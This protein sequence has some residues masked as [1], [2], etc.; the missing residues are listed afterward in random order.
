MSTAQCV[1]VAVGNI[2][3]AGA[4]QRIYAPHLSVCRHSARLASKRRRLC[5]F[6][7][8]SMRQTEL[9][10]Y[11]PAVP[12][13]VQPA[14]M[15][16]GEDGWVDVQKQLY[17]DLCE[18]AFDT[19]DSHE[20][21]DAIHGVISKFPA[22]PEEIREVVEYFAAELEVVNSQDDDG[23]W[24]NATLEAMTL[25]CSELVQEV[26][27]ARPQKVSELEKAQTFEIFHAQLLA[28]DWEKLVTDQLPKHG[29]RPS[30]L[31]ILS[32]TWE[33]EWKVCREALGSSAVLDKPL[34]LLPQALQEAWQAMLSGQ[35]ALLR[36]PEAF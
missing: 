27:E 31:F 16:T 15:W 5:L 4:W 6:V 33:A 26:S 18:V 3:A 36:A 1:P 20:F 13:Q 10:Q 32:T 22:Y 17:R 8:R 2:G 29:T 30:V 14:A 7:S 34:S 9:D 24:S 19:V 23:Q 12:T 28:V 21:A 11:T 25:A 35:R